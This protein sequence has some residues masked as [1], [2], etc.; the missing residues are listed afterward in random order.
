MNVTFLV[1]KLP[2]AVDMLVLTICAGWKGC[3]FV[4]ADAQSVLWVQGKGDEKKSSVLP[5]L[6]HIVRYI[7]RIL[8]PILIITLLDSFKHLLTIFIIMYRSVQLNIVS[9]LIIK[10]ISE[11]KY[12]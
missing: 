3:T 10:N 6:H 11:F 8:K 7:L 4:T 12:H 2:S 5:N 1:L 9:G